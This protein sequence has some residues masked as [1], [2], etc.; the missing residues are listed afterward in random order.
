MSMTEIYD[1][2]DYMICEVKALN[3][4]KLRTEAAIAFRTHC[5]S[6]RDGEY[7]TDEE[8]ISAANKL[9]NTTNPLWMK[10]KKGS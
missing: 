8:A 1:A 5:G 2:I 3:S 6:I 4:T 10:V 9:V 7:C